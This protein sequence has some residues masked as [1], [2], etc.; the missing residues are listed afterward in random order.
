MNKEEVFVSERYFTIFDFYI[1][2][3]QFLLRSSKD[4]N[5][6]ENIDI[7]FY[8]TRYIQMATF[9]HGVSISKISNPGSV[10]HESVINLLKNVDCYLFEISSNKESYFIVSTFVRVYENNLE[11]TETSLG[12]IENKGRVREIAKSK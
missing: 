1:S 8:D 7:I 12:V 10:I 5:Y 11:F 9:L 6:S 4:S 3:G 2:H